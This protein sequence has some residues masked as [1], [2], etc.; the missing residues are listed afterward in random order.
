MCSLSGRRDA[1]Y[2]SL[3]TT[4][5]SLSPGIDYTFHFAR[6]RAGSIIDLLFHTDVI[7]ELAST[8]SPAELDVLKNIPYDLRKPTKCSSTY[9][10][11]LFPS[12]QLLELHRLV[13]HA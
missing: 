8:T 6:G 13:S 9:N 7:L 12:R 4:L 1:T 2:T 10:T 5:P 3:M 11:K